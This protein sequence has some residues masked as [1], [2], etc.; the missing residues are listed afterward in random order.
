MLS[1]NRIW[2]SP[3]QQ[4]VYRQ[5]LEATSYPGSVIDLGPTIGNSPSWL[6]ILA[7]LLDSATTLCDLHQNLSGEDWLKLEA[8]SAPL[9]LSAFVLASASDPPGT[10]QPN[11]GDPQRP[12]QGATLILIGRGIHRTAQEGHLQLSITGPGVP[13]GQSA[14]V[15]LDGFHVQWFR[16]RAQWV[17]DFPLGVDVILCDQ[18]QLL[19]LPR[20]SLLDLVEACM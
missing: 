18:R 16:R 10:A 19:A 15:G 7:C 9:E 5:V 1:L 6:A 3:T 11:L 13:A 17:S 2:Q 8:E 4:C 12:D 14:Q 20:T